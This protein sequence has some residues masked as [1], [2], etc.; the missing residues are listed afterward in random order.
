M[1]EQSPELKQFCDNLAEQLFGRRPSLTECVSCGSTKVAPTDFR[2]DISRKE[3]TISK[4]C[5]ACQDSVF[6]DLRDDLYDHSSD[7]PDEKAF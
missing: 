4:M 7:E 2:D 5:Q 1:S 6:E 3:F